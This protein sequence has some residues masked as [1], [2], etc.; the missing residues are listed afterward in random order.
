MLAVERARAGA[1]GMGLAE[2]GVALRAEQ[3]APFGGG[4]RHLE[5]LGRFGG[6]AAAAEQEIGAAGRGDGHG[7][8]EQAATGEGGVGHGDAPWERL[9]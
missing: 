3:P 1:L 4:L 7:G 2:H 6:S 8:A 9:M 5:P